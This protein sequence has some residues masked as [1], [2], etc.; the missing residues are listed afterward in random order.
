MRAPG[1]TPTSTAAAFPQRNYTVAP[2]NKR[3][4]VQGFGQQ[5]VD[6][7]GATLGQVTISGNDISRFITFSVTK[8][9]LGTPGP[10]WTFTLVL[11][12]QDGFS[13]DQARGFQ[14][15]PQGFQFGV[16]A[17][18]SSD[19]HCTVAPG[20]VPKAMDTLTPPAEL[21]YTLHPVVLTALTVP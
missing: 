7:G 6:A 12:G 3:I 2:W 16:C 10:G 18:A 8:A 14:A 19:P 20:T 17:T 11:T 21:D 1:A 13:P 4:E 5:Y 15:T 9:S